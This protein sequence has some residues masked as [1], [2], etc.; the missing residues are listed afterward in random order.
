MTAAIL[1]YF[2]A[3]F[4]TGVGK[5][6]IACGWGGHR[7][8]S[9][10]YEH[11]K[12][13]PTHFDYPTE[14]E[15]AAREL[16]QAS[17]AGADVYVCPY[18]MHGD[19]RHKAGAVARMV[20]HA[21]VDT[22][23]DLEKIRTIGG[24]AIF[25]GTPG[26]THVYV[27]LAAGVPNHHH[28]ALERALVSYLG[29]DPAKIS[30]N[31]VLRPP[32]TLNYKPTIDDKDPAEVMWLL[33]PSDHR[34]DPDTLAQ[35]FGIT[36]ETEVPPVT[37]TLAPSIVTEPVN[38]TSHPVALGAMT[39]N[40]GDRSVDTARIVGACYDSNLTLSQTR[41]VVN[42]RTDLAQRLAERHDDDVYTTWQKID[43]DRRRKAQLNFWGTTEAA[44]IAIINGVAAEH[45]TNGHKP[46]HLL[47]AATIRSNVPTWVWKHDGYGRIQCGTLTILAGRPGVGKSNAA[48]WFA[49][50][51]SNGTIDGCW[52]GTPV[53]VAYISPGEESHAY[54]IKPGLD[55][56]GANTQRIFFPEIKNEQGAATKLMGAAHRDFL[57]D[58]FRTAD[59]RVVIV[60]PIMSTIPGTANINQNNETR[61]H[62][63]PWAQIATA[64][65][66]VVIGVAHFTKFPG[67][68]LVAAINGSSAFGEVARA[69]FAFVKDRKTG[70]RIFSQVKNSTGMEDLSLKYAINPVTTPTDLGGEASV[71][72]FI[73][74]ERSEL[75]AADVITD[76]DNDITIGRSDIAQLWLT[77]YLEQAG[78]ER[79]TE[80]VKEA[81]REGHAQ[82][83]IYRAAK[84]IGVEV[85][86]EGMPRKSWWKLPISFYERAKAEWDSAIKE[87]EG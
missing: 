45:V 86:Y 69:I 24:C 50:G 52:Y 35:I 14:R 71:A 61:V 36:L 11:D 33:H 79:P 8:D 43:D 58:A 56:I 6:H 74:G 64:L 19:K 16:L 42:A 59:V 39:L 51:Y 60:D 48:R 23:F 12:W 32:D 13:I 26:H 57:I 18:L 17:A 53:N 77:D 27:Q 62:V 25:S 66:G 5:L 55:A 78:R 82:A 81:K 87:A 29:G 47:P 80:I 67:N 20:L 65:D 37:A 4:G 9:G 84:K 54:V 76:D 85:E 68:D 7:N 72:A 31:D 2:D 49:A 41:W 15:R 21:D 83:T 3:C 46:V 38:L 34:A 63:E 75:T 22:D 10:R 44:P 73:I 40:T 28:T 1:E 70:D 30:D